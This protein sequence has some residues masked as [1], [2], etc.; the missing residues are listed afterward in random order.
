[1]ICRAYY[2][3]GEQLQTGAVEEESISRA[4]Q[5]RKF[6]GPEVLEL[7]DVPDEEPRAGEVRIAVKMAGLNPVDAKSVAGHFPVRQLEFVKTLRRALSLVRAGAC[8][9][10][11]R[12]RSGLRRGGRGHRCGGDRVRLG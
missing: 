9:V 1:M 2:L 6:G 8:P 11:T 3:V 4:V 7:V 12:P 10:S 5:Y